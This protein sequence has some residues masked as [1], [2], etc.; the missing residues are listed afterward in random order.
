MN[1]FITYN[2]PAIEAA[3][4]AGDNTPKE[5]RAA[6]KKLFDDYGQRKYTEKLKADRLAKLRTKKEAEPN[7]PVYYT[8][9]DRRLWAKNIKCMLKS[10]DGQ[11]RMAVMVQGKDGKWLTWRIPYDDITLD[12]KGQTNKVEGLG[13]FNMAFR[14]DA[15]PW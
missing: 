14:V 10:G 3:L 11:T 15:Q 4:E 9:S 7:T 1:K 12:W 6:L 13:G 5:E 8:G 2:W